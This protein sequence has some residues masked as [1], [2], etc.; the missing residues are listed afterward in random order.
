MVHTHERDGGATIVVGYV[1]DESGTA[2]LQLAG[3]L[4]RSADAELLVCTVVV[5]PW[6]PN[7]DRMDAEYLELLRKA[8]ERSLIQ[9]RARVPADVKARFV[10]HSAR[11]TPTGLLEVASDN[12][13]QLVVLG[14]SSGGVFGHVSLGSVTARVLHSSP[15]AVALAPRGFRCA[16]DARVQ[17]VTVSFGGAGDSTDLMF[18]SSGLADRIGASMRAASFA[19]SPR[20]ALGGVEAGA[21]ELVVNEWVKLTVAAIQEQLVAINVEGAA[22]G[23]IETVIGHG[24]SW[25]EALADIPWSDGDIMSVGSSITGPA[26]RVFLGSRAS[27]ILRHS[28]VPVVLMPRGALVGQP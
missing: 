14:S 3:M 4:A 28:P 11:S 26:A 19:V 24:F 8:A 27:K 16:L 1:P 7:P 10:V 9:A 18:A 21:E 23:A 15:V 6:P 20:T 17:R 12:A 5:A 25:G 2:A 13:A 22:A